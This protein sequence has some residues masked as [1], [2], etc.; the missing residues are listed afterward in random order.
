MSTRFDRPAPRR[1]DRS[2]RRRDERARQR[3]LRD[4]RRRR[5]QARR[6][7]R[8][9][10]VRWA[11]VLLAT[12]VAAFV[13][14]GP[15]QPEP[16]VLIPDDEPLLAYTIEYRNELQGVTNSTTNTIQRP[17]L[18]ATIGT[19]GTTIQQ[20]QI[21]TE[22]GLLSYS[23]GTVPG[24]FKLDTRR[25]RAAGDSRPSSGLNE[26]VRRGY[27]EVLGDDR[28]LGRPCTL[29]RTGEPVGQ[30]VKKESGGDRAEI[31]IDRTGVILRQD[32]W[33]NGK[34][35]QHQE[36]VRFEPGVADP[37][38]FKG[39]PRADLPTTTEQL[40][41]LSEPMPDDERRE[42]RPGLAGVPGFE[43]V[44]AIVVT[45]PPSQF[46]AD[47]RLEVLQFLREADGEVLEVEYRSLA[48]PVEDAPVPD[49][50]EVKLGRGRVGYLQVVAGVSSLT[51]QVGETRVV[52]RSHDIEALQAAGRSLQV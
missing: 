9:S 20:G 27:A 10:L 8:G 11:L 19:K 24:W 44:G 43:E 36:A 35:V 34:L 47:S 52:I 5:E 39:E 48:V 25:H 3:E 46:E 49:G 51:V 12:V 23:T 26:A 6:Q 7:R 1:P 37:E 40:I 13:G 31:C 45:K 22:E 2:T 38:A 30:P 14:W 18:G 33:L 28:V 41:D 15:A 42:L 21:S 16:L 17:Y 4:A 50:F 32:W 29:V